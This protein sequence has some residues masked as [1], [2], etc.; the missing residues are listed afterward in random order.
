MNEDMKQS[1]DSTGSKGFVLR[2]VL[3]FVLVAWAGWVVQD[4]VV[5]NYG[6]V[7]DFQSLSRPWVPNWG[8]VPWLQIGFGFL[9]IAAYT[10]VGWFAVRC[11][12]V[13]VP[14]PM[15]IG[16]S[17]VMGLGIMSFILELLTMAGFLFRWPIVIC[18]AAALVTLWY[19]SFRH[20]RSR[21]EGDPEHGD[22]RAHRGGQESLANRAFKKSLL[23]LGN[24]QSKLAYYVLL[25][26]VGI[27]TL[28]TFYHGI[29]FAETYWDSLILYLGYGRMTYL[30]GAFPFKAVA[31][32]GYGLG[33]NYPHLYP[34]IGSTSSAL[35]GEWY[36]VFNQVP[37]PFCGLMAMVTLY[38]IICELSR[39]RLMAAAV[40]LLFRCTWYSIAYTTFASDYSVAILFTA[41]FLY[42]A[43]KYIESGLRG[44]LI[45][46][47]FIP[48]FAM[49]INFL[50]GFL[51]VPWGLMLIATHWNPRFNERHVV[52]SD[53]QDETQIETDADFAF[54]KNSFTPRLPKL[55]ASRFFLG[56]VCLCDHG[57]FDVAYP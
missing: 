12:D 48:A 19:L 11:V 21:C 26:F 16:I 28:L 15:R 9:M 18:F 5:R 33:A 27:I 25:T 1:V 20:V 53:L 42:L 6:L 10:A 36:D 37:P 49:H 40:C 7:Y 56:A 24:I 51:W 31:Q 52:E 35:W 22:M 17:Y 13:Y 45:L 3:S 8:G 38:Y 39:N 41:V 4:F 29:L 2:S 54:L 46:I 30:Y 32:V 34:M 23:P 55:L 50:M 43:Y 14:L 47:T 44:Y 57:G